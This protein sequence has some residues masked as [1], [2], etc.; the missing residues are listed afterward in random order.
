MENTPSAAYPKNL[1]KSFIIYKL[2]NGL[3][4][5]ILV[6]SICV[7]PFIENAL[8]VFDLVIGIPTIVIFFLAPIGLF[9]NWRSLKNKEEFAKVRFKYFIGH[10]FLCLLILG[11]I[12]AIIADLRKLF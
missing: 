12:M 11:F 3:L 4:V 5:F 9:Y 2:C 6:I 1:R 10:L 8:D 7:K